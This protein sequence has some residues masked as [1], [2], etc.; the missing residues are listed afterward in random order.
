M[1][2]FKFITDSSADIPKNV[3]KELDITVLPLGVSFGGESYLD[4]VDITPAEFYAKLKACKELPKTSQLNRFAFEEIFAPY[5]GTDVVPVVLLLGAEMSSTFSAAKEAVAALGMEEQV[6]LI[7]SEAVT[8]A[9]AA[10]VTEGAKLAKTAESKADLEEKLISLRDRIRLYAYVDDLRYLRYGGRLSA[11]SMHFANL[12]HIRPVVTLNK[13]V[14]VVSKQI[15]TAK[16]V[17]YMIEKIK[18]E[19]DLSFP[20]YFANSD[21]RAEGEAFERRVLAEVQSA[22][23]FPEM[24]DIGPTVGTHAGPGCYGVAFVAKSA[25]R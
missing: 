8:F 9:L 25:R 4:G 7:D 1:L 2:K 6:L 12:L 19:A 22:T 14:D 18:E 15:G 17:R 11:A 5:K 10:L 24:H 16:C 13:K 20:L 3:A 23:P 21:C